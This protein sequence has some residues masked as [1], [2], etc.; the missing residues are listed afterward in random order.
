MRLKTCLLLC[1]A[2]AG[3]GGGTTNQPAAKNQPEKNPPAENDSNA[4]PSELP[5]DVMSW[6]ETQALVAQNK[7]KVVVI[8]VWATT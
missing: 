5:L 1:A 6:E 4:S 7:G 3:C 2:L 8:D